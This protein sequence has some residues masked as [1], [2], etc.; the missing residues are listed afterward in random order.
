MTKDLAEFIGIDNSIRTEMKT[1][2][3]FK[4]TFSVFNAG[5]KI[6]FDFFWIKL[7]LFFLLCFSSNFNV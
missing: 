6:F 2:L 5:K 1:D 3:R 7:F 4:V